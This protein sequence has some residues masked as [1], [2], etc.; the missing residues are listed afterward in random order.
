MNRWVRALLRT[1]G[2][3]AA[4]APLSP[5]PLVAGGALG[6]AAVVAVLIF[7]ASS[8]AEISASAIGSTAAAA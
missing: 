8:H 2:R 5:R 1:P 6:T 4:S 7:S 3:Y